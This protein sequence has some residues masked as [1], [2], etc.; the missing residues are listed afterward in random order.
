[1]QRCQLRPYRNFVLITWVL[2]D[3]FD[4]ESHTLLEL[5][6]STKHLC[7]Y[8]EISLIFVFGVS[9]TNNRVGL[10]RHH[11]HTNPLPEMLVGDITL[12]N[13]QVRVP[14]TLTDVLHQLTE[15]GLDCFHAHIIR[16]EIGL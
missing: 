2:L 9:R 13:D 6:L 8:L 14:D 3:C 1:M 4:E 12:L 10:I 5:V 11:E 15:D 7:D 16:G